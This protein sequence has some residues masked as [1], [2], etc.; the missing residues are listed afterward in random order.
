MTEETKAAEVTVSDLKN[1]LVLIDLF[2]QRGALRAAELTSV[3]TLYER[4]ERF[5]QHAESAAGKKTDVAK[6]TPNV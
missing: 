4:I 6:E 3:G 5:V 1:V 2:A